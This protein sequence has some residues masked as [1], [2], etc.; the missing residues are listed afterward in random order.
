MVE[1]GRGREGQCRVQFCPAAAVICRKGEGTAGSSV[2][3]FG[4]NSLCVPSRKAGPVST[5]LDGKNAA[6]CLENE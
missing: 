2:V 6:W 3:L 1:Q 5:H 4:L